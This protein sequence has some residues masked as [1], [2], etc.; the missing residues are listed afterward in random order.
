MDDKEAH[1]LREENIAKTIGN[2]PAFPCD[3]F[4]PDVKG[5]EQS[6]GLTKRELFAAMAMQGFLANPQSTQEWLREFLAVSAVG[7]AD[8]L[9]A[10]LAK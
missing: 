6:E 4:D 3:V 9:L 7:A 10:E 5:S 1:R 8:A 2:M